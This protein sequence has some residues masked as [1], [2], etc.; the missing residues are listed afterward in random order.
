MN[1]FFV[2]SFKDDDGRTFFSKYYAPKVEI[3]YFNVLIYGKPFFETPVKNKEE[4]YE[5]I[6][7]MSKNN[8]HT[9]GSLLD[10]EYY[11]KYYKLVAVNLS[12]QIELEN[13]V[14]QQTN[15]VGSL[16]EDATMFFII[17]EKEETS[18]DFSQNSVTV[19]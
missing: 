14:K 12:K 1:R 5:P 4:A 11:S 8:D 17:E 16:K 18:F 10:Y 3:K 2:L 9:T 13:S 19:V 6:I 15:F 7:E